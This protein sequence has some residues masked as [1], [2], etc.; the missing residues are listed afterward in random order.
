MAKRLTRTALFGAVALIIFMVEN[1][2]P[3]LF[4]FAPGAKLGLSNAVIFLAVILLGYADAFSVLIVKLTF[5]SI[6]TGQI[7][8]LMYSAPAGIASFAVTALL[9]RFAFD[10]IGIPSISLFSAVVFNI[11]QLVIAGLI[12]GVN[13]M[14]VLPVMLVAGVIA[15]L[16]V[17]LICWLTVRYLPT[18]IL[19]YMR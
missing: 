7:S 14:T 13:L 1:A 6:F 2:F 16:T 8:A 4:A 5:G 10:R 9:Y 18:K 3:P 17:G 12:A 15:G 19:F 11:V